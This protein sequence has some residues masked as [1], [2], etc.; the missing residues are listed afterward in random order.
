MLP[1]VGLELGRIKIFVFSIMSIF[2]FIKPAN[3]LW[4]ESKIAKVHK[5]ILD[6]ITDL[7]H[8]IRANRHNMEFVSLVCNMIENA[9]INNGSKKDKLKI[10]KKQLLIQIFNSLYGNM[11]PGD[12]ELLAK[13]VEFLWDNGH[14][15]KHPGWKLCVYG[16]AD[17]VKRKIL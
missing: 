15:V 6:A 9:G 11:S 5:R 8:E 14:I 17:W 1:R 3:G 2:S 7:P 12:C 4:K 10:D 16:V 13:N